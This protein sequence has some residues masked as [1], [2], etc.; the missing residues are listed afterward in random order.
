V[1][2]LAGRRV[3]VTGGL[4][5]LGLNLVP[6]LLAAGAE[7]RLVN[8]SQDPQALRW[9]QEVAGGTAVDLREGDIAD[10]HHLTAWLDGVEVIVNLA[11]ESGAVRSLEQ[12]QRDMEVNIRGH[13]RLLETLRR[14][15][16][17]PRVV[18][19]SSRLV[20][21]VTGPRPVREDQE[22]CPTSLY[23]LHKLTVEH[24]HRIYWQQH[25]I[26]Y[27]ILRLTN[28]YGPY[29]LPWR[30]DY[31]IIN[32]FIMA[33][34]R[35]EIL[36]VYGEGRQLR[37]YIHVGD[38][39]DA[40]VR[41]CADPAALAQT[42]NVGSGASVPL[43]TV[44]QEIVRLADSGRVEYQPWPEG[45]RKV[46]TGDFVCSIERLAEALGWRPRVPLE[47]GLRQAVGDY[48]RLLDTEGRA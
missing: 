10:S 18:F 9:L 41:A 12:A 43:G 3:L 46:E 29:Q 23:G 15:P 4:G 8:R 17:P 27:T 32:R 48:R 16:S 45:E 21:G 30:R 24:Y 42:F 44:A 36:T 26:P 19:I 38:V 1:S 20:Y 35:G 25:G 22:A 40:V 39:G 7:L 6:P 47:Q 33:A 14:L 11:G 37:D 2:D 31:G 13:L 5:F 28:P 34:V